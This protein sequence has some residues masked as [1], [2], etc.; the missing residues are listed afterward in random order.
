VRF[1]PSRGR[2]KVYIIDEVHMLTGEAFNALL[3]TLE[4]PPS[5]VVFV[6]ATTE[7]FKLPPTILSRCQRFDFARIPARKIADHLAAVLARENAELVQAGKPAVEAAPAALALIARRAQGGLRTPSPSTIRRG[8]RTGCA[9]ISG[10]FPGSGGEEFC[11]ALVGA[12]LR[13]AAGAITL[14]RHLSHGPI[15]TLRRIT[16]VTDLLLRI[17][18][19]LAPDR[20]PD[21]DVP[22]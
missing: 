15:W 12:S 18:P 19:E 17:G 6:F 5:H 2:S 3:K 13:D 9:R 20:G 11:H 21:A 22:G 10:G 1:V 7:P 14:R 8:G 16:A 4:E